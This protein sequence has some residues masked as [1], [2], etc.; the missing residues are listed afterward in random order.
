MI[1]WI[2]T[3]ILMLGQDQRA[4]E[5]QLMI[6]FV[7]LIALITIYLLLFV[8]ILK[9]LKEKRI[10]KITALILCVMLVVEIVQLIPFLRGRI[11]VELEYVCS[12]ETTDDTTWSKN[13]KWY[14]NC[15]IYSKP[16]AKSELE[17]IFGCSLEDID[18]EEEY[19][20]LFV[21]NYKDVDL[22]YTYWSKS[23]PNIFPST[24]YYWLGDLSV[25]GEAADHTI[26]VF[27]FP[28]KTI[29]RNSLQGT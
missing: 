28:R 15:S 5:S 16:I 27:R 19:T 21:A 3:R 20:Y 10:R 7:V 1:S 17:E 4:T 22:S 18:F 29:V 23:T 24:K 12:V 8:L 26:Y 13:V 25:E 14:T 11:H 2:A 6:R 9:K